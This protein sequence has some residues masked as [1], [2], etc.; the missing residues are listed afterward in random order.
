M[1]ESDAHKVWCPFVRIYYP[2]GSGAVAANRDYVGPSSIDG[3]IEP[4]FA[5]LGS[6]CAAWRELSP[7]Y[8]ERRQFLNVPEDLSNN[9]ALIDVIVARDKE[10]RADGY[11]P[12]GPPVWLGFPAMFGRGRIPRG[13]CGLAGK[14]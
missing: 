4:P 11:E 1:K 5:C 2:G 3:D 12:Y 13:Y 8:Q 7:H 10:F 14:P 6:K 9:A